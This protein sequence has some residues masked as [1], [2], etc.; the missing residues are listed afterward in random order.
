MDSIGRTYKRLKKYAKK[1]KT[2]YLEIEY[3]QAIEAMCERPHIRLY[4]SV[5]ETFEMLEKLG[6]IKTCG[7]LIALIGD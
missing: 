4:T 5:S 2:G 6:R 7:K 3:I 1:G